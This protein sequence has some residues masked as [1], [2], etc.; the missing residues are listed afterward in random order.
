MWR[1]AGT[2]ARLDWARYGKA[3][4]AGEGRGRWLRR[5]RAEEAA[6]WDFAK[7]RGYLPIK[8]SQTAA[9]PRSWWPQP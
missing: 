4:L 1:G 9:V 5:L 3:L 2:A 6:G 7:E 8:D